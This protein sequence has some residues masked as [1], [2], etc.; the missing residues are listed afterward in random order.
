LAL[1]AKTRTATAA[2]IAFTLNLHDYGV[3]VTI[4]APP[5]SQTVDGSKLLAS[6]TAALPKG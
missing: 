2:T 5:A 3:P 4:T 6:L 1:T